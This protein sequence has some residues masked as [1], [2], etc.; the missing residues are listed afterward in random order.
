MQV[1]RRLCPRLLPTGTPGSSVTVRF[2][3][4]QIGFLDV[5]GP[6]ARQITGSI[7][8]GTEK[9]ISPFTPHSGHL[10]HQ[11]FFLPPVPAGEHTAVLTLDSHV[12]DKSAVQAKADDP[13]P[14]APH[15]FVLGGIMVVGDGVVS[16]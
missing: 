3:G 15:E 16:L 7:D 10:R 5:D 1:V 6:F 2:R 9:V 11:Y 4:T 8:E 13:R 12:P 14:Y